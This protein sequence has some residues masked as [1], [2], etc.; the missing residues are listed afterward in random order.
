MT[1]SRPE[2]YSAVLGLTVKLRPNCSSVT[3][4]RGNICTALLKTSLL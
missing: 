3:K 2:E 1:E 4:D